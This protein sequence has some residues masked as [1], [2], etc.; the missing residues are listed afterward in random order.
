VSLA[1]STNQS[2]LGRISFWWHD[3]LK[4]KS[5]EQVKTNRVLPYSS[6]LAGMQ[7]AR[8]F[9]VYGMVHVAILVEILDCIARKV[10]RFESTTL[11]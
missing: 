8:F 11:I 6:P 7:N 5:Q 3:G 10:N 2:G 4:G 1:K 9:C